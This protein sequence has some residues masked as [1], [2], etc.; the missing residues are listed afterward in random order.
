MK[1]KHF[2]FTGIA[3]PLMCMVVA[4]FGFLFVRRGNSPK[5]GRIVATI[6][7]SQNN[8]SARSVGEV[9]ARVR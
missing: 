7:G 2:S 4:V 9:G 5:D 1:T 8:T 3:V 6:S